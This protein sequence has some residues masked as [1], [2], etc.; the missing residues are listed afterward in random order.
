MELNIEMLL[1]IQTKV[2]SIVN[3]PFSGLLELAGIQFENDGIRINTSESCYGEIETE[4]IWVSYEEFEMKPISEWRKKFADIEEA[5]RQ[6]IAE[7]AKKRIE[8]R[9]TADYQKYLELKEKF[10]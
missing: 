6:K 2:E 1:D 10:G 8:E 5:R 3:A 4:S 9:K 7:D